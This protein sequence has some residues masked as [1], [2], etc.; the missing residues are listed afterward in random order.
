MLAKVDRKLSHLPNCNGGRVYFTDFVVHVGLLEQS[1]LL[2]YYI[3]TCYYDV[4]EATPG[5]SQT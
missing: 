4:G 1:C 3:V 5:T 2:Q